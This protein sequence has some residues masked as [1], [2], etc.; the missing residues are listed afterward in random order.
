MLQHVVWT[1]F[2]EVGLAANLQVDPL[3]VSLYRL[4]VLSLEALRSD[5]L[6]RG[7]SH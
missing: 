1:A 2:S 4:M 3:S 5:C 7:G 6:G